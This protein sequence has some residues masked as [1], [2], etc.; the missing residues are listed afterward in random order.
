M[1]LPLMVLATT[2]GGRWRPGIGDPSWAGWLIVGAYAVA[3]IAAWAAYRSCRAEALWRERT[4]PNDA[5]NQRLLAVF[6]LVAFVLLLALGLNKQLDFQSLFTQELRDAAHL[7][8]WYDDRRRYQFAFV[9]AIAGTGV[10]SVGT[11]AWMLRD[12]LRDVWM[13]VLGLGGLTSFV[14]IRAASFHHV[15]TLL[16][17][18]THAGNVALELMAIAMI[19]AGAWQALASRSRKR[20]D[21]LAVE[22]GP[23]VTGPERT[24]PAPDGTP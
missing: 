8:G 9:V 12:V 21:L 22:S 6:W 1:V 15:D 19:A 2:T 10:L 5:R 3:A 11:M 16:R 23:S 14:V 13:P 4:R 17:R 18:I 7:E 24:R 20:R